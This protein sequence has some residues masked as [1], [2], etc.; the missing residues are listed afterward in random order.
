MDTQPTWEALA[1]SLAQAN[2]D[3]FRGMVGF[4]GPCERPLQ[5]LWQKILRREKLAKERR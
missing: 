5:K 3:Y 1:V 2:K 4:P